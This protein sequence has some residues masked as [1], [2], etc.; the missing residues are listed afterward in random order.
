LYKEGG[1]EMLDIIIKNGL[2]LDTKKGIKNNLDIGIKGRYIVKLGDLSQDE[3]QQVINAQ[4]CYVT[5]GLIDYH[6]HIFHNI[7]D[8][9]M[10]GDINLLQHGVTTVVDGGSAGASNYE[11][12]YKYIVNNSLLTVKS[13]LHINS[14]GQ[15]TH[16]FSEDPNPELYDREQIYKI[17]DKYKDT[18]V[19]I[20]LR[21]SRDIVGKHGLNC[22][23]E[24]IKVAEEVG[25]RVS[26]H[27]SDPPGEVKDTLD[28]LR[29]GDIFCH[30][31]HGKG[32]TI[33]DE[34]GK[35]L[36]EVWQAREK[37]ILFE[38]GHGSM[39]F[40]T[41]VA[42]AAIE[43]GFY[44][45]IISSDLSLLSMNK[46]PTYSFSHIM[47]KLLNLGINFEEIIK[48]SSEIPSN[49]LNIAPNGFIN[50]GCIADIAIFKVEERQIHFKD[51]FGYEFDGNKIIKPELTIKEGLIVYRQ[52]D[53]F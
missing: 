8:F 24:T 38:L 23:V 26:V 52:Y 9:S 5:P 48:R 33:L 42:K 17:C 3:A 28:L 31:Y 20:K 19:G 25:L 15:L 44:P 47:T 45:D 21:Q 18:I 40:S 49:L 14:I 41:K 2:V 22:L 4:G 50:E 34:K 13:F 30:C 10:P 35:V 43:Q 46:P 27:S 1:E 29:K 32:K 16:N 6:A 51:R 7:S 11:G 39:Q 12:F 36:E 53:F 37:G